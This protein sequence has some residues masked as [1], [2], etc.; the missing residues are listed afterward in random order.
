MSPCKVFW[1]EIFSLVLH[2]FQL[3]LDMHKSKILGIG[4]PI[5][6]VEEVADL[7][8]CKIMK[9]LFHYLGLVIG[10]NMSKLDAWWDLVDKIV[11]KL[12]NWKVKT[13]SVGVKLTLLK[14]VLSA[15]L[16]YFMS[17]FKAPL[18]ILKKLESMRNNFFV[19]DGFGRLSSTSDFFVASVR[20]FIDEHLLPSSVIPTRWIP[21]VHIKV[22]V[23]AWRL[24]L[25]RVPTKVNLD[26]SVVWIFH[27]FCAYIGMWIWSR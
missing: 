2:C 24:S 17:L 25:V 3:A 19:G 10:C 4:I 9:L 15:L 12:Y 1:I 14:S 21:L 18:G 20:Y 27:I 8:E 16:N 13:L 23:L 6:E 26:R 22:N 5:R 7:I 11:S